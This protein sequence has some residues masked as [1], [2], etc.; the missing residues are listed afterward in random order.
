MKV[1][2]PILN[3]Y[4]CVGRIIGEINLHWTNILYTTPFFIQFHKFNT[5][6]AFIFYAIRYMTLLIFQIELRTAFVCEF[7]RIQN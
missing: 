4:R 7:Y 6:S 5:L 3:I 1:T 2:A